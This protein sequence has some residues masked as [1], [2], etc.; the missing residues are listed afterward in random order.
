MKAT[1]RYRNK[2]GT[3]ASAVADSMTCAGFCVTDHWQEWGAS[4]DLTY[5]EVE[6]YFPVGDCLTVLSTVNSLSH[7]VENMSTLIL[8]SV[9][10]AHL[11]S[12]LASVHQE[13]LS[14][15]R[16]VHVGPLVSAT[17]EEHSG[18]L[19]FQ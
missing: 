7:Y 12:V 5:G 8:T 17:H 11:T 13:L 2:E 16:S 10:L 4:G 6:I 3:P 14:Q 1:I 18:L 9:R 19:R 15:G